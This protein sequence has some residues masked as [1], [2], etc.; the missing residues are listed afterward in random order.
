MSAF[1]KPCQN[2]THM[3]HVSKAMGLLATNSVL[4]NNLTKKK[5]QKPSII[6]AF[7]VS[8]LIHGSVRGMRE[9][10]NL[11]DHRQGWKKTLT[12]VIFL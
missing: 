1:T 11:Q 7:M 12:C 3:K 4:M 2:T 10:A 6:S 5:K 8:C 9:V